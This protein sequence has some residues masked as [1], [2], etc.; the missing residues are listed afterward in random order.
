MLSRSA[1]TKLK[2]I[3]AIDLLIVTAAAGVYFYLQA[4]GLIVGPLKPAEFTV[5]DLKIN[6]VEAEVFEPVLG[7]S[8]RN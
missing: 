1:I 2:A 5:T 4:E 7:N 6:P 8:Q 3:L